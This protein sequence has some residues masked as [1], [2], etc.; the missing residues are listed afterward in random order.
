MVRQDAEPAPGSRGEG[1][2]ASGQVVDAVEHFDYYA[3]QR[4]VGTPDL[5]DEFGIVPAFDP[6]A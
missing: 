5:G 6:D 1:G 3:F 4:E 2:D